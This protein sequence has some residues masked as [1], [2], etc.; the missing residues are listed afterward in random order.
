[1]LKFFLVFFFIHFVVVLLRDIQC[2]VV[3][4]SLLVQGRLNTFPSEG[5]TSDLKWGEGGG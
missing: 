4:I 1:M 5:G 2:L 3:V